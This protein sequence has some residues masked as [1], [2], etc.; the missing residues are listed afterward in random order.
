[1]AEMSAD[2]RQGFIL[3]LA[4]QPL[5]V[6]T[7]PAPTP[8]IDISF[9]GHMKNF[10]TDSSVTA[11]CRGETPIYTD[12]Y[13]GAK[14]WSATTYTLVTL[15]NC[16]KYL[17]GSFTILFRF[18]LNSIG[19]AP[20]YGLRRMVWWNYIENNATYFVGTEV[21]YTGTVSTA[22][23]T[24]NKINFEFT[25]QQSLYGN[26]A[27]A[28]GQWH[29]AAV[30]RNG[31]NVTL[32]VDDEVLSGS[33]PITTPKDQIKLSGTNNVEVDANGF[34]VNDADYDTE[35][36]TLNGYIQGLKVF[37]KVLSDYEIALI[38]LSDSI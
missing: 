4:M 7:N 33:Y 1:M 36:L 15:N 9:N 38:N 17:G 11:S 20:F 6:L 31:T 34:A 18:K 3:G 19:M 22:A 30:R 14:C 21:G 35:G 16:A 25:S 37:D 13:G 28:D 10:G 26:T 24:N 23:V 8:V 5:C 12:G 32:Q 29:T 27:R 2:F